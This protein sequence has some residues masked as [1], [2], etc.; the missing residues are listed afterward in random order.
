MTEDLYAKF[1]PQFVQLARGR[2]ERV[3]E[4]VA[5]ADSAAMAIV[6]RELHAIAGEAGLLGQSAVLALARKGE[7]LAKKLRDSSA[8]ADIDALAG[9]VRDLKNALELVG[10]PAKSGG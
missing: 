5:R 8:G 6:A 4:S 1:L 2:L 3:T 7:D 9:T 10:A